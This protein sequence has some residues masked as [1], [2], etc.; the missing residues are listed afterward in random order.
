MEKL[1]NSLPELK[2]VLAE[3]NELHLA[4]Q[5]YINE[6]HLDILYM[7]DAN[8]LI[9]DNPILSIDNEKI[10]AL[11]QFESEVKTI[12]GQYDTFTDRAQRNPVM[13][14]IQQFKK[15]YRYDIYIPSHEKFVGKNCN[16]KILDAYN[17]LRS[18]KKISLLNKVNCIS[19][20]A[21]LQKI[22]S[23]TKLK[24]FKCDNSSLADNLAGAV[25]CPQC[26]FPQEYTYTRIKPALDSIEQNLDAMLSQYEKIIVKEIREYRDNLKFLEENEKGEIE[27]ILKNEKL[28]DSFTNTI[29]TALNKLFREIDV[30]ELNST[31]LVKSL[32]PEDEFITVAQLRE[33]FLNFENDLVKGKQENEVRIRLKQDFDL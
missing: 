21:F 15:I 24:K 19:E 2:L 7:E 8:R 14:K 6:I 9:A 28:P 20:T 17:N 3:I 10:S 25:R 27:Y 13:G 33:R 16:W 32:F 31:Q 18:F 11:I 26:L 5:E 22:D 23:W 30:V 29:V 4:L 1:N 12:C